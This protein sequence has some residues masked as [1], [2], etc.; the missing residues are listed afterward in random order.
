[1]ANTRQINGTQYN[2]EALVDEALAA[3]LTID[4][5][6]ARA[7]LARLGH[8]TPDEALVSRYA[9]ESAILN[10]L[11]EKTGAR[12]DNQVGKIDLSNRAAAIDGVQS[13]LWRRVHGQRRNYSE[14]YGRR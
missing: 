11:G 4:M 6:A 1:M 7:A 2:V 9:R 5:N 10:Y 12:F 13:Y 8:R 14:K 3:E